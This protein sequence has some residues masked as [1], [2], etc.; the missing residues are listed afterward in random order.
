MIEKC[1]GTLTSA[2]ELNTLA[3]MTERYPAGSVPFL[4]TFIEFLS[5]GMPL[6]K[7]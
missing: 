4:F 6:K 3:H 1:G 2:F 7:S 5:I